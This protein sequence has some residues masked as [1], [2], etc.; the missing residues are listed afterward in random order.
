MEE[1]AALKAQIDKQQ[2]EIDSL[3]RQIMLFIGFIDRTNAFIMA[4]GPII[5]KLDEQA[6]P[7]LEVIR[8]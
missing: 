2:I 5:A 6:K 3:K 4:T 8:K 7:K 1:I